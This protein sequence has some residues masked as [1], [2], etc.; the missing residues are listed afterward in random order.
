MRKRIAV[1]GLF[2]TVCLLATISAHASSKNVFEGM[3]KKGVRG[4]INMVTGVVEIPMQVYKGYH[5]GFKP[6][7]NDFGSKTV[8]A[9]LGIFRGLGHAAGRMSWGVLELVGFWS[10][11]AVDNKGVG[12][13]LDAQLA[14]EMGEQ[15]SIFEPSLEEGVKPIG[16]K[17]V[18]GLANS[19][20]GILE[21]P[22]QVK[23]GVDQGNVFIGA[24][25]GLW[26]WWSREIYGFESLATFLVPNP[27]DNPGYA[28][29][30]QWPWSV[31]N[32]QMQ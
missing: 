28:Y 9:V 32:G 29:D 13:P 5:F 20:L 12:V 30:G 15:Y 24:G 23:Q 27:E 8:G 7:E 10:A 22:G 16:Q 14:W 6:I 18:L 3:G 26:F 2:L 21:V 1:F 25:R 17:L 31:L 4:A 19:F 11:N